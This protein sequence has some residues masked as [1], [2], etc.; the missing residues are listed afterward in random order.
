MLAAIFFLILADPSRC[1]VVKW[2]KKVFLSFSPGLSRDDHHQMSPFLHHVESSY[3]CTPMVEVSGRN[4]LED[5]EGPIPR[6]KPECLPAQH[7]T[8]VKTSGSSVHSQPGF[9]CH[10]S[11]ESA[12]EDYGSQ[13]LQPPNKHSKVP[14]PRVTCPY[15]S[16]YP[17]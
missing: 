8:L 4:T 15:F 11:P 2:M 14:N 16:F 6:P 10:H 1:Y 12:L 9:S 17:Q 13:G 5:M 7:E 3:Q